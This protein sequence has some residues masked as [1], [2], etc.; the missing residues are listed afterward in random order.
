M[1]RAQFSEGWFLLNLL[2]FLHDVVSQVV[3]EELGVLLGLRRT[4]GPAIRQGLDGE[5]FTHILEE[6]VLPPIEGRFFLRS[7]RPEPLRHFNEVP[8][9]RGQ[10]GVL[11]GHPKDLLLRHRDLGGEVV[12]EVPSTDVR[13]GEGEVA[14]GNPSVREPVHLPDF[15]PI[16][17]KDIMGVR[18]D[19]RSLN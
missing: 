8:Q 10:V 6:V 3:E 2:V 18:I 4:T 13:D 1:R 17:F 15:L 19:R 7:S 5:G 9:V 14:G 11:H 16:Q 12:V